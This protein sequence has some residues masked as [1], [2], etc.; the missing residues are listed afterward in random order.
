MGTKL[1]A[2]HRPN[3]MDTEP[4]A[5]SMP[6]ALQTHI[7]RSRGTWEMFFPLC[8]K[9]GCGGRCCYCVF[10][11]DVFKPQHNF[12]RA[13]VPPAQCEGRAASERLKSV[14]VT[15]SVQTNF[16]TK[17]ACRECAHTSQRPQHRAALHSCHVSLAA[18]A[19]PSPPAPLA[20]G[21]WS[22]CERG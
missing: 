2:E 17:A 14:F 7:H 4:Y 16:C 13:T 5:P 3:P 6:V 22:V 11:S 15:A 9:T 8:K 1:R 10:F 12:H 20:N 19:G 18:P 21:G